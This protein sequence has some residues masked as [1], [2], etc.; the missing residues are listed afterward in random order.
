MKV[1]FDYGNSRLKWAISNNGIRDSGSVDG[2]YPENL[3]AHLGKILDKIEPPRQVWISSVAGDSATEAL[4]AW[5]R[6]KW[7]LDGHLIIVGAEAHGVINSYEQPETLGSDR[8]A[9]LIGVRHRYS[10]PASIVDCGTAVTIDFLNENRFH[11]GV[12]LP[13]LDTSRKSLVTNTAQLQFNESE[14]V[15]SIATSTSAAIESGTLLG[16]AG[17][18]EY[19]VGLQQRDTGQAPRIYLTGGNAERIRPHL[20]V[21]CETIDDLVLQGIETIAEL[22]A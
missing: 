6:R 13:G 19:I 11:G 12:I 21:A 17:A 3:P 1:L 22:E 7:S 9:A 10:Q 18:I 16:L 15:T 5:L 2:R 8:W 4:Q 20:G 14:T